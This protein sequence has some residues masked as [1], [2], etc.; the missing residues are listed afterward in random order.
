MISKDF[1][2]NEYNILDFENCHV[3]NFKIS[4][5]FLITIYGVKVLGLKYKNSSISNIAYR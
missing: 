5:A 4:K 1:L 3:F 2:S